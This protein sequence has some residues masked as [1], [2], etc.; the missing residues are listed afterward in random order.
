MSEDGYFTVY[1][2]SYSKGEDEYQI[3]V[4]YNEGLYTKY[5]VGTGPDDYYFELRD[6]DGNT[7]S[8]A[9]V[10]CEKKRYF[11]H[12]LRL[13]FEG[14]ELSPERELYI[15]LCCDEVGYP[16]EHTKGILIAHP[17][18]EY[19]DMHLSRADKKALALAD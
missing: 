18:I 16:A 5:M 14:V 2:P 10:V 15:F 6:A 13:S 4:R 9:R 19:K 7:V 8:K 17:S 3:T 11:Y 12:H 1:S